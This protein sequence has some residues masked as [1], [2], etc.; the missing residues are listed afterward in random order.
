ME[1]GK[2]EDFLTKHTQKDALDSDNKFEHDKI[3]ETIISIFFEDG[4][5]INNSIY[6]NHLA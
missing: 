2:L 5:V 1:Y 6:E 4:S 3:N